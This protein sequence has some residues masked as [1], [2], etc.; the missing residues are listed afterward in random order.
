[1]SGSCSQVSHLCKNFELLR[2]DRVYT[3]VYMYAGMFNGN[4]LNWE[5]FVGLIEK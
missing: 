1:M 3:F 5:C 2:A 4:A